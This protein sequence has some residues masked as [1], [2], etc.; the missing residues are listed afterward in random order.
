MINRVIEREMIRPSFFSIPWRPM[1]EAIKA[2]IAEIP[3]ILKEAYA[4][5]VLTEEIFKNGKN[6]NHRP[7]LAVPPDRF[8]TTREYLARNVRR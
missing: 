4:Q 1:V 3:Y 2:N 6:P 8:Q 5:A 7:I